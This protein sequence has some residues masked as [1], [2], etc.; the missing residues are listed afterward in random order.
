M[1][2]SFRQLPPNGTYLQSQILVWYLVLDLWYLLVW[3][4]CQQL[5][6]P[7]PKKPALERNNF[8]GPRRFANRYDYNRWWRG[9]PAYWPEKICKLLWIQSVMMRQT[10][11][12]AQEDMVT[13]CFRVFKIFPAL[14]LDLLL[15]WCNQWPSLIRHRTHLSVAWM[16]HKWSLNV[17]EQIEII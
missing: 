3:R 10:N 15:H 8:P 11:L 17:W 12:L 4:D 7:L 16:L 9:K 14:E 2:P 6:W 5:W 1:K 13:G